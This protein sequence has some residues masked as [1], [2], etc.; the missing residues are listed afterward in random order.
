MGSQN[1]RR[2]RTSLAAGLATFALAVGLAAVPAQAVDKTKYI[3]LGDSYAAGQGA[4][5]YQDACYRSENSYSELAAEVKAVKLITNA[6]CSGMTTQQVVATQLRQLNKSTELVTITAG[7]NNLGVGDIVTNCGSGDPALA[8]ACTRASGT[9]RDLLESGRLAQDVTAMIQSVQAAAPNA[10]I[11]VTGY[12]Y[13]FDP[14][15]LDPADPLTPF[16]YQAAGLAIGLDDAIAAAV[17]TADPK[18]VR[19]QYVD[20]RTTFSGHGINSTEPWINGVIPGSPDSFHPNAKGYLAYYKA[21]K[22]AGAYPA[23]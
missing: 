12:P 5:P 4:G 7:G 18:A 19:V 20:V 3:A 17:Q 8:E 22:L 13:L 23:P 11:V 16:I 1:L 10:K 2:R 6:A 15:N 21:L 9:A 14:L